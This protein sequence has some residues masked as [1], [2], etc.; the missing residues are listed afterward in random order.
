MLAIP[1]LADHG[2]S[3]MTAEALFIVGVILAVAVV[4][5]I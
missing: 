5:G 4:R 2:L 1:R 3:Q